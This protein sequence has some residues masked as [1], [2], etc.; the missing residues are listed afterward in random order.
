MPIK[1]AYDGSVVRGHWLPLF[2]VNYRL[3]IP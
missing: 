2:I 1:G 3:F